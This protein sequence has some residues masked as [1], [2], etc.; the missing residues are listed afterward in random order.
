MRDP[1][2]R[3]LPRELAK[4]WAKYAAIFILMVLLISI[5]SGM[6]VSNE[7]LKKGYYDSFE[8]YT[9]EDG[10]L[11]LDKPLPEEL[12][13][14]FEEKGAMKLYDNFYFDVESAEYGAVVRVYSQEDEINTPCLLSGELPAGDDEIAIDRVFAKNNDISIGDSITL[15]FMDG[16]VDASITREAKDDGSQKENTNL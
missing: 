4:D 3:R 5:C 13:S 14:A 8:K 11:T 12:R 9:L 15:R 6:R 1:L 7:S 16:T 10:H 2:N